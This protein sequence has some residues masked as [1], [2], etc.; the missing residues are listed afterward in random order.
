MSSNENFE[1]KELKDQVQDQ[2]VL[3]KH[4]MKKLEDLEGK[5]LDNSSARS[6][7][8]SIAKGNLKNYQS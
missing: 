4:M 6:R 2:E 7:S 3:I 1:V 8:G 5:Q